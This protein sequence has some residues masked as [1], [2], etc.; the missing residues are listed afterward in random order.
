MYCT[1]T[2]W[3]TTRHL[4]SNVIYKVHLCTR[5]SI[6]SCLG[7]RY[8]TCL[9]L[10]SLSSL[11]LFSGMTLPSLVSSFR[12]IVHIFLEK[13]HSF[14]F[15]FMQKILID[16]SPLQLWLR[17]IRELVML[18]TPI[19]AWGLVV[20]LIQICAGMSLT[21]WS[22]ECH[23]YF[24]I[25]GDAKLFLSQLGGSQGLPPFLQQLAQGAQAQAPGTGL[26]S[27][28]PFLQALASSGSQQQLPFVPPFLSGASSG[29]TNFLPPWLQG[30]LSWLDS[31]VN[32]KNDC[33]RHL[34]PGRHW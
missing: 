25:S 12:I 28:P 19:R 24:I 5:L 16:F 7:S 15:K 33:L 23:V 4:A 29:S 2:P 11:S 20:Q 3:L 17:P 14:K 8:S 1:L 32:F 26:S 9:H 30:Y 31:L 6:R 34:W 27:L 21:L 18:S 10:S 22:C 13:F